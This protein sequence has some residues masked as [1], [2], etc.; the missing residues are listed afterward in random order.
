MDCDGGDGLCRG[1]IE[2]SKKPA[3]SGSTSGDLIVS[4]F[5]LLFGKCG[6]TCETVPSTFIPMIAFVLFARRQALPKLT[7][8]K[9]QVPGWTIT[10][11]SAHE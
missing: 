9:S 7:S 6:I 1:R 11:R 4:Y 8:G 3:A 10:S 5:G 2:L